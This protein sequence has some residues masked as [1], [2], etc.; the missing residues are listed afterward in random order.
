[1]SDLLYYIQSK[2]FNEYF[3]NSELEPLDLSELFKFNVYNNQNKNKAKYDAKLFKMLMKLFIDN[4]NFNNFNLIKLT[5]QTIG[6]WSGCV[7]SS[8]NKKIKYTSHNPNLKTKVGFKI[9]I[10]ILY[11]IHYEIDFINTE[12]IDDAIDFY[13]SVFKKAITRMFHYSYVLNLP[14][15]VSLDVAL[16]DYNNSGRFLKCLMFN[17]EQFSKF[18]NSNKRSY[19]AEPENKRSLDNFKQIFI[20]NFYEKDREKGSKRFEQ[21]RP[22]FSRFLEILIHR[23][24]KYSENGKRV[25][26]SGLKLTAETPQDLP[27]LHFYMNWLKTEIFAETVF[28]FDEMFSLQNWNNFI[29]ENIRKE[30]GY[31]NYWKIVDTK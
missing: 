5:K 3:S 1:M 23:I 13:T 15:K 19:Q 18:V 4:K 26:L 6:W 16:I 22:N 10:A 25:E 27:V 28:R 8:K 2:V 30:R 9:Y 7:K 17:D 24:E 31:S 29:I 20:D 12:R 21:H 14:K 11:H